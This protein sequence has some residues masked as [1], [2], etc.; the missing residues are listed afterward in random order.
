MAGG[1][2]ITPASLLWSGAAR[3]AD[4]DLGGLRTMVVLGAPVAALAA[5]YWWASFVHK[6]TPSG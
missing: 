6:T 2:W 5:T 4:G 3:V 1:S